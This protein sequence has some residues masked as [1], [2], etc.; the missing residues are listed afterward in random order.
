M[1]SIA[2]KTAI[3]IV[4]RLV[5]RLNRSIRSDKFVSPSPISIANLAATVATACT[6]DFETSFPRPSSL[7]RTSV[8]LEF[9]RLASAKIASLPPF[10]LTRY[11]TRSRL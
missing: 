1:T 5:D 11:G 2:V 7:S 10:E 6:C 9:E 8:Q 3:T 4:R